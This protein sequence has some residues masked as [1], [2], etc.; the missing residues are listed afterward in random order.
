MHDDAE[1]RPAAGSRSSTGM[2]ASSGVKV[3]GILGLQMWP[4]AK[5]IEGADRL[6]VERLHGFLNFPGNFR[7]VFFVPMR[8]I[9]LIRFTGRTSRKLVP[10][11]SPKSA[12]FTRSINI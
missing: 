3:L 12:L 8:W 10:N 9:R 5:T 7:A 11:M 4:L 2:P 1:E 6:E